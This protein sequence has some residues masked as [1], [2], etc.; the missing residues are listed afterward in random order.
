MHSQG[1][2]D[3]CVGKG[4]SVLWK[5]PLLRNKKSSVIKYAI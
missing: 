1:E 3:Q 5:E 4:L 2:G